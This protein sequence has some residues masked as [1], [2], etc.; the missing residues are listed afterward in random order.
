MT[1]SSV[2]SSYACG[3]DCCDALR[4][5]DQN[6]QTECEEDVGPAGSQRRPGGQRTV[7]SESRETPKQDLRLPPTMVSRSPMTDALTTERSCESNMASRV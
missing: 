5:C 7:P 2:H 3:R 1:V 4:W 6:S